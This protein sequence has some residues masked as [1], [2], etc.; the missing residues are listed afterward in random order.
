[1]NAI[2]LNGGGQVE[3]PKTTG[4]LETGRVTEGAADAQKTNT[5]PPPT[6]DSIN[7]SERATEIH[8]L[9][10]KAEQ[11]PDVREERVEKLRAQVQAGDYRPSAE[12]IADA[13]LKDA[14]DST[15]I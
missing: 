6:T 2:K 14:Q 1:M 11:L 5:A 10:A 13:L 3:T 7:V 8:E 4:R 15:G 12:E 9:T